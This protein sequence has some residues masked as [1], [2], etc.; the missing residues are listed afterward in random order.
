MTSFFQFYAYKVQ[1]LETYQ[2]YICGRAVLPMEELTYVMTIMKLLVGFSKHVPF[3]LSH[4]VA[5]I[6]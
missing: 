5:V 1:L 2:A 3:V 4:D 6:L